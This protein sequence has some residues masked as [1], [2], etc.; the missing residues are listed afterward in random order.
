MKKNEKFEEWY[1]GKF[2]ERY[3]DRRSVDKD[4]LRDIKKSFEAGQES[5]KPTIWKAPGFATG[6]I[7]QPKTDEEVVIPIPEHWAKL[8]HQTPNCSKCKWQSE[9]TIHNCGLIPICI[10]QA[11]KHAEDVYN[12][13]EC[14]SLYEVDEHIAYRKTKED[15]V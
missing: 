4:W 11:D 14:Q 2:S 8:E 5:M 3:L 12:N 1:K 9:K 10:A 6:G 7:V 13:T 15:K